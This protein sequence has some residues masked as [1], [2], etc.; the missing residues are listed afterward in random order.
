MK[1][2][3]PNPYVFTMPRRMFSEDRLKRLSSDA[4]KAYLYIS[5]RIFRRVEHEATLSDVHLWEGTG[6]NIDRL[7]DIRDELEDM[8]LL[9][10][11]TIRGRVNMYRHYG[12]GLSTSQ[13]INH[14]PTKFV[15]VTRD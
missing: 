6:I 7:P 5:L 11:R 2:P 13:P 10:V 15:A 8:Q 1:T 4:L 3:D 14:A 9:R 12:A